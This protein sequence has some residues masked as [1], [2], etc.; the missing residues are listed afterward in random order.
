MKSLGK[1][2]WGERHSC[3]VSLMLALVGVG[4]SATPKLYYCRDW[5]QVLIVLQETRWGLGLVWMGTKNL[6]ATAL[7]TWDCLMS[8][9][10]EYAIQATCD[11]L[12]CLFEMKPLMQFCVCTFGWCRAV[13]VRWNWVPLGINFD[14]CIQSSCN[15]N[16]IEIKK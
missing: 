12:V 3:L 6:A 15:M 2:G 5:E 13:I 10:T 11:V 8:L 7:W 9:C 14:Y 1:R 16:S 4:R